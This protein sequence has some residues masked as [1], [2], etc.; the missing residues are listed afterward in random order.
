[1]YI[2][3]LSGEITC[4][5]IVNELDINDELVGHPDSIY[6]GAEQLYR[7]EWIKNELKM[8]NAEKPIMEIGTACGFVLNEIDG[9]I[10]IDIRPDRLLIAKRKY[11]EKKFYYGNILNLE[12]FYEMGIKTVIA[13]EIFEHIRYDIAHHAVIHC[14]R[15][16]GRIDEMGNK[17]MVYYTVPNSEVD[18]LVA[19][20]H[21]HLWCPT[22]NNLIALLEYVGSHMKIKYEINRIGNFFCGTIMRI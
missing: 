1:M 22:Y 15:C 21:E 4:K 5:E 8:R 7:I 19:N 9:D 12:P 20:N 3:T 10:G 14:L 11:P 16:L 17:G 13:A 6:K 2:K 18:A